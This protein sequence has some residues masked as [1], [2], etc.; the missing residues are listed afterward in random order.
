MI[1]TLPPLLLS[2]LCK[3]QKELEIELCQD[4]CSCKESRVRGKT[5]KVMHS[6]GDPQAGGSL[7]C[8]IWGA[9]ASQK[10]ASIGSPPSPGAEG[11][12]QP[13]FPPEQP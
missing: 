9:A 8:C 7:G 12:G 4:E 11:L 6:P 3:R 13:P 1:R 2:F 10:Q 5:T